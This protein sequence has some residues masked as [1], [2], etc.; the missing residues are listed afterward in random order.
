[1]VGWSAAR[2]QGGRGADR[3]RRRPLLSAPHPSQS[4]LGP[5]GLHPAGPAMKGQIITVQYMLVTLK[6]RIE[7]TCLLL[8]NSK[9]DSESGLLKGVVN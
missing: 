5:T 2:R 7:D 1:M 9:K 8:I 3:R 6:S 4:A